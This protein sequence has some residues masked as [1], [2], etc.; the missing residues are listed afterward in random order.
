[1]PA[2]DRVLID[3]PA[4]EVVRALD[5][6]L[7][8][9]NQRCRVGLLQ[10]DA[11]AL[12]QLAR[13]FAKKPEGSA[14]WVGG[15]PS[16][17][18]LAPEQRGTLVGA[19]W[20]TDALGRKH[21]RV[22]G[23]RLEP[24]NSLRSNLFGPRAGGW[25]ALGLVYPDRVVVRTRP[26]RGK[27]AGKREV[28][29]VCACGAVGRPEALAWMGDS[30][31]PC[32]D[33]R[34]EGQP[35]RPPRGM[36]DSGT[37][38]AGWDLGGIAYS[39]K[40]KLV[41][42]SVDGAIHCGGEEDDL[43]VGGA[44]GP[45][46]FAC[47]GKVAGL[48]GYVG[49]GLWDADSG[50]KLSESGE[51]SSPVRMA[52]AISP[53]GRRVADTGQAGSAVWAVG[54]KR[55]KPLADY[56][57][58]EGCALVFSPDG[59]TLV[60]GKASGRLAVFGSDRPIP[61]HPWHALRALAFSPDGGTLAVGTGGHP[62]DGPV[63]VPGEVYLLDW[64]ADPR[65]GPRRANATHAESVCAV[66]FS[67]DGQVLASGGDDRAVKLWDVATARLLVT[68]EWHLGP[69]RGVAFAPSGD[70]L[71]SAGADGAVRLWAWRHFL[72]D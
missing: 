25:P 33:R 24:F 60:E 5:E 3:P 39:A 35:A 19:A 59:D 26:G 44:G 48:A 40:G 15:A 69:V 56:D 71:A 54:A 64:V 23:R 55:W 66:A 47:N 62:I 27:G 52:L 72:E 1:M 17:A 7:Q 46:P 34:Q 22:V 50:R 10:V 49:H 11:G 28:L 12:R 14:T 42:A 68:L 13:P 57:R 21:L 63:N 37:L 45:L 32:Y 29:A 38:W 6:A 4:D 16:A 31:G 61:V 51:L 8:T 65:T 9:A 36:K 43:Y 2:F 70:R 18:E 53:D 20:W 58:A 67:P 30:C 41:F